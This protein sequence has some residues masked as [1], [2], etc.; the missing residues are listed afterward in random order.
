[1]MRLNFDHFCR[2][3]ARHAAD[4]IIYADANG[5]IAF[6]NEGAERMFGFSE[7]EV[8]GQSLDIIIPENLRKR[9]WDGFEATMRTGKTRYGA[10]D[11]LAVPA[12]RKN[13]TRISAEFTVL[14]FHDES[15][16]I[17]GIAAIVRDVTRRFEE[18]R[19]LR[20]ELV[21]QQRAVGG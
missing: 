14:P 13:G 4:A 18:V 11:L 21:A 15:G 16:R 19:A 3:L 2:T 8:M 9:H 10:G 20:K 17:V 5:L 12:I 6:W 7:S 1:M